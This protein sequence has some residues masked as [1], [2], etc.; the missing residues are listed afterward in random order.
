V[1]DEP[2][3]APLRAAVV[4]IAVEAA[5]VA[6]LAA[7][8]AYEDLTGTATTVAG[9]IAVTAFAAA[10]AAVLAALAR[11]LHRRRG[12]ARGITIVLQLMLLA[13]GYYATTGGQ[14][15]A[16][17]PTIITAL[18][19]CGLLIT[20]ASTRALGLAERGRPGTD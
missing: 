11:A 5:A 16:G 9:A 4:L 7:F 15:W 19:V 3:P 17:V 1:V 6:V 13:I 8:L 2:V 10:A 12:G 14:P 18:A 20:P